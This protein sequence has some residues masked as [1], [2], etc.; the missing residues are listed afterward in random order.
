MINRYAFI[1]LLLEKC[2]PTLF[3]IDDLIHKLNDEGECK[4]Y[5]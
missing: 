1:F 4:G 3:T 2:A 5:D